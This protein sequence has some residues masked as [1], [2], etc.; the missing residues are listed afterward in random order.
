MPMPN[1]ADNANPLCD[2]VNEAGLLGETRAAVLGLGDVRGRTSFVVLGLGDVRGKTSFVVLVD[3]AAAAATAG[4]EVVVGAAAGVGVVVDAAAAG[5]KVVVA[6][7]ARSAP[8]P[9][10]AVIKSESRFVKRTV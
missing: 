4:T 9:S 10:R 1:L 3:E 7:A 6:A 2:G 5:P 8:L